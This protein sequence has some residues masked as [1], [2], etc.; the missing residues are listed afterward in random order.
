M[1]TSKTESKKLM[2][3]ARDARLRALK[4]RKSRAIEERNYKPADIAVMELRIAMA[5]IKRGEA[6]KALANIESARRFIMKVKLA[7]TYVPR[8]D[9]INY[10]RKGCAAGRQGCTPVCTAFHPRNDTT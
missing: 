6:E 7:A 3:S 10:K 4:A 2:V 5:E 1:E 8:G 9:C